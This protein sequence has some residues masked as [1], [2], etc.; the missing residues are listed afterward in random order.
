MKYY[1]YYYYNPNPNPKFVIILPRQETAKMDQK[2]FGNYVYYI[3]LWDNN[4]L[5]YGD[6]ATIF[7][8]L[9]SVVL[10]D[11]VFLWHKALTDVLVN[12]KDHQT[13][14]LTL[15]DVEKKLKRERPFQQ[16]CLTFSWT[17]R[18][19]RSCL[20]GTTTS[21]FSTPLDLEHARVYSQWH[22]QPIHRVT[23]T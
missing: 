19:Y 18:H 8:E 21:L 4:V 2:F 22:S 1:Y 9:R 12:T 5:R 13:D 10:W 16:V 17:C 15:A 11:K 14:A 6:F 7:C 23:V 20:P 3:N